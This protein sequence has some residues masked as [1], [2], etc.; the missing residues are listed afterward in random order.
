VIALL[1]SLFLTPQLVLPVRSVQTEIP[2]GQLIEK[3]TC[4]NNAAQT[5]ALYLPSN[6]DPKRKWP[7]L[8]AFDPGGRG[9]IPVERF[10]EAAEKFGWIVV[11]SNTSRN[12]SGV[13]SSVDAWNAMARD[14]TTRFSVDDNRAYAAG[15]S[16]GARMALLIASQC[17][18]CLAGVIAG[19]AG[20]PVGIEPASTMNFALFLFAGTDDFN[21]AEIKSLEEG[22]AR[23]NIAHQIETFPGRHE[24]LP[25]SM[26][27]EAAGWMELMA[28]K[29]QRRE[30]DAQFIESWQNA[31]LKRARDFENERKTYEAYQS[32]QELSSA[33]KGL[34]DV[35]EFDR[36]MNQLRSSREVRDTIRDEQQQIKKQRDLE[37][38]FATLIAAIERTTLQAAD[39]NRT[40]NGQTD[41]EPFDP[42]SRLRALLSDLNR[43]AKDQQDT[44][45]RR[46]ARRVLESLY[47]GLIERGMP[48]LQDQKRHDEAVRV[49]RLATEVNPERPG[50]FYYLALVYGAKADKKKSLKALQTAVDRGFTDA[51]ALA[52]NKAFDSI[53]DDPEFQKIVNGLRPRN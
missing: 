46:I 27:T 49:F 40:A 42:N 16:G 51:A 38:Q 50:G 4:A 26:A 43:Q 8:Y 29:S 19:G 18:D 2:K 31:K 44:A 14:T 3:V 30:R 10:K 21:Y 53:R 37:R 23:A 20:F 48:L 22:L 1:L 25:S 6:Y 52:G 15:F 24:W 17:K 35:T 41:D 36:R 33:L 39:T 11:G 28:M 34:L 12:T 47:V 32:Y 5:Y 45:P 7:I 13:Q 9:K